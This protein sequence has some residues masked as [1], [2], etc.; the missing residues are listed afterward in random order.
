MQL[1]GVICSACFDEYIDVV[2]YPRERNEIQ[3][4]LPQISARILIN[5]YVRVMHLREG[6]VPI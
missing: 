2:P 6:R 1:H 5:N 4:K 3:C